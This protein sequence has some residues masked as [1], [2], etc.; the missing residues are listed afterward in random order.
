M[1]RQA[2]YRDARRK[3]D[4]A[5]LM[6]WQGFSAPEGA[7][8]TKD[9]VGDVLYEN[10]VLRIHKQKPSVSKMWGRKWIRRLLMGM[11]LFYMGLFLFLLYG[12]AI[13]MNALFGGIIALVVFGLVLFFVYRLI[14][15]DD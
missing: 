6:Y 15:K 5:L 3:K 10:E 14:G 1:V 8:M 13:I 2:V 7:A 4:Q 9:F 12:W 11:R